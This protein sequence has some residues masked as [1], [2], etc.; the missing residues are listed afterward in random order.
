M[1]VL[2]C[3][4]IVCEYQRN[5][6]PGD[7]FLPAIIRSAQLSAIK[8]AGPPGRIWEPLSIK[9]KDRER[10]GEGEKERERERESVRC[11]RKYKE[12]R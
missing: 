10:E 3:E 11:I 6:S 5:I 9:E 2:D 1:C 12:E 4:K 7:P 8:L